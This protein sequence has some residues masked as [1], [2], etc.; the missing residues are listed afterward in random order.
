MATFTTF[1]SPGEGLK[2]IWLNKLK[3]I[4]LHAVD[5]II[6]LGWKWFIG[7]YQLKQA[8]TS[9]L[10]MK[11]VNFLFINI[12]VGFSIV[13]EYAEDAGIIDAKYSE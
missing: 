5:F 4:D 3:Q 8:Y 6:D 12:N 1:D 9:Q 10:V 2:N 7:V 13:L 11:I